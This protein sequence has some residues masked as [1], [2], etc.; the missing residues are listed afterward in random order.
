MAG[1]VPHTHSQAATAPL[2]PTFQGYIATTM[3]AL[4]LF[5]ACL[6]GRIAH[7]PRRPHDRERSGLIRSGNV[8]IYEEHSSGIKRWTDGVPWSPSRILG[9]FLLYRE[10]D[11]PF[12][13][14]EKKRAMKKSKENGVTKQTST[15]R[16]SSVGYG[17]MAPSQ[18]AAS[19]NMDA[20]SNGRD[21]ERAL[22]GSLVD[23]YQFKPD[24]LVKKT[25]SVQHRGMQHHMVSYYNIE[26]VI[27][28]K[29]RTPLETPELAGVTPRGTLISASNFRAPVDDHE[30]VMD[31]RTRQWVTAAQIPGLGDQYAMSAV[32]R[33]MSVPTV[34]YQWSQGHHYATPN[35][36]WGHAQLPSAPSIGYGHGSS[37][38]STY[39]A[40]AMSQQH[41]QLSA[42]SQT[43]A[44]SQA[45][46]IPRRHSNVFETN[47]ASHVGYPQMPSVNRSH[48]LPS[49]ATGIGS[50][51]MSHGSFTGTGLYDSSAASAGS[52]QHGAVYE[53]NHATSRTSAGG[54][55]SSVGHQ[56]TPTFSAQLGSN[57]ESGDA[58]QPTTEYDESGLPVDS[59]SEEQNQGMGG[60]KF[61]QDVSP[62]G[63]PQDGNTGGSWN[64]TNPDNMFR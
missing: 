62:D 55:D 1:P 21:L 59:N 58:T 49:S 29:L 39:D 35:S 33:S 57:F 17:G 50:H 23:S 30:I 7:V 63:L 60:I 48:L 52:G 4:V 36:A 31:D 2:Q 19:T 34:P 41:R 20:Y 53:A 15:P 38:Y 26:D 18:A 8:F 37:T 25:I 14:G 9:N 11:K 51:S 24:G 54:Y 22:V 5:E 13:P 45:M 56:Q 12:Q 16:S 6:S 43:Y 61:D 40:A 10:L 64:G 42:H 28:R 3:D 44:A 47:G 46:A 27:N 32:S